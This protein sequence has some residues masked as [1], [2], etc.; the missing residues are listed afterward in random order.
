[1]NQHL[2]LFLTTANPTRMYEQS[3]ILKIY[4]YYYA[5]IINYLI[6]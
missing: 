3:I 4:E 1:M 6:L 5:I 2:N